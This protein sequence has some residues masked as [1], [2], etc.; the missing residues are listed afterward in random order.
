MTSPSRTAKRIVFAAAAIAV[1]VVAFAAPASAH[2]NDESY[3]YLD[4]GEDSLSGRV[5]M[6]YPEDRKSVV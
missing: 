3:L 6:P 5:E 4:V 2:R 1:L